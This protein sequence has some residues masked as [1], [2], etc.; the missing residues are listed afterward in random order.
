M[1]YGSYVSKNYHLKRSLIGREWAHPDKREGS[2]SPFCTAR[3]CWERARTVQNM[4]SRTPTM[5]RMERSE[6]CFQCGFHQRLTCGAASHFVSNGRSSDERGLS[7]ML[8]NRCSGSCAEMFDTDP[9]LSQHLTVGKSAFPE[10]VAAW[11]SGFC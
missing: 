6:Y 7:E 8:I 2:S 1:I 4:K 5:G 9:I 3:R 10:A 11:R